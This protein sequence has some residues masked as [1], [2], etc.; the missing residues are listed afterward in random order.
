MGLRTPL[1][2][3]GILG[4]MNHPERACLSGAVGSVA[5]SAAWRR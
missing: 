2:G 1:L 3:S 4:Y 5:V